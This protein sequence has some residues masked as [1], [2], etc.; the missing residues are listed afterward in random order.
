MEEERQRRTRNSPIEFKIA[1]PVEKV[2]M[3]GS[4]TLYA[5]IFEAVEKA[6]AGWL[7]PITCASN[8][9]AHRLQIRMWGSSAVKKTL[10]IRRDGKVLYVG[11]KDQV[12]H[13]VSRKKSMIDEELERISSNSNNSEPVSTGV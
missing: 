8:E 13:R 11:K 7:V 6:P 5:D 4:T 1:S 2:P 9:D 12:K 3:R 10:S